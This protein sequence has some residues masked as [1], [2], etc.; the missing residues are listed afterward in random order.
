MDEVLKL[1]VRIISLSEVKHVFDA[2][3]VV[4]PGAEGE[5]GVLPLHA[6]MIVELKA[7]DLRIYND[8]EI[9]PLHISGGVARITSTSVDILQGE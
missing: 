9:E 3:M 5:L 7:G 6:P 2:D 8:K 1:K 4:I